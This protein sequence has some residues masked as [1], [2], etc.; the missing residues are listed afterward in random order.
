MSGKVENLFGQLPDALFVPLA[1][2][3]KRLYWH[4]LVR[5]YRALFEEEIEV[6]EYG[7]ARAR[8]NEVIDA[9]IQ[10]R[11]DL[12][13]SESDVETCENIT[14]AG[15]VPTDP[16]TRMHNTYIALRNAGWLEE[17][18]RG[19]HDYVS[20]P[21]RVSQCLAMLIEL[22][23]G[24]PLI[25]TGKLKGLEAGMRQVLGAPEAQA[26]TLAEL[27]KD[28]G[29]FARHVNSIRGA[30]KG[31]YDQ[32]RGNLPTREIV[33]T[34]FED[35]LRDILVRDY[36]PIKT[37]ENP[38]RIRDE[39]LRI[40]SAMRYDA[41]I[42]E[43][44]KA[45][46]RRLYAH[47]GED[48]ALLRLDQDLSRLEQVFSNIDAQ[49]DAIDK[50]KLRY[51]QRIDTVIEYATRA[52][53]SLGRDLARLAGALARHGE[54]D[55]EYTVRVPL[56][57]PERLGEARL[58]QAKRSRETPTPRVVKKPVI[59]PAALARIE[60]ERAARQAIQVDDGALKDYLDRQIGPTA[61]AD[62]GTLGV[63]TM[64]DYFC[65]LALRRAAQVPSAAKRQFPGVLSR[66]RIEG[67][68]EEI[69]T[70]YFRMRNVR[71]TRRGDAS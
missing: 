40:V 35:F 23:E 56:L 39:L 57:W 59:D 42:K 61:A 43:A 50:M 12:W 69:E 47:T 7:H 70:E 60:R 27:A 29:R 62:L 38:L 11:P 17:E 9:A 54:T 26:D 30:I 49:L 19:Y 28:A 1:S 24:R 6:T 10:E 34:F 4:V 41:E 58:A 36:A 18:R 46:Y 55:P 53:R 67:A 21:P 3:N 44:L 22:A 13:V 2:P 37:S 65:V 16:R 25:V 15:E 66:Y 64:R 52:P 71:V 5:L 63:S 48:E 14:P 31:L 68:D 32:I 8:V 45:G 20:M 51:E 33:A